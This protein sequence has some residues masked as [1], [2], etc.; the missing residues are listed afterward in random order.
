LPT[1]NVN[2]NKSIGI[3]NYFGVILIAWYGT[4]LKNRRDEEMLSNFVKYQN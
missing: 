4:Y 3:H 2:E 1:K